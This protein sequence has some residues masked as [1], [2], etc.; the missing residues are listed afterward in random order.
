M[1]RLAAKVSDTRRGSRF[2]PRH[3]PPIRHL[4]I[5]LLSLQPYTEYP[6]RIENT[7]RDQK[8]GAEPA[9]PLQGYDI[10]RAWP[11]FAYAS[12]T[13]CSKVL[14]VRCYVHS[15]I[16]R[17]GN[18]LFCPDDA[19]DRMNMYAIGQGSGYPAHTTPGLLPNFAHDK[20]YTLWREHTI[21]LR[22]GL[23]RPLV[24]VAWMTCTGMIESRG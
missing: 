10:R 1:I 18:R 13:T 9:P 21:P 16:A 15:S 6:V 14:V 3:A 11:T 8:R 22:V 20:P 5:G 24:L 19:Y 2:L 23:V 7:Q 4:P 17:K 12:V